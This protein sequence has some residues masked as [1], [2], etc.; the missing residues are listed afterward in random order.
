[1]RIKQ[2]N[3]VKDR[4][5]C[6]RKEEASGGLILRADYK[7]KAVRIALS[8]CAALLIIR[9]PSQRQWRQVEEGRRKSESI[10][11]ETKI[12]NSWVK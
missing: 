11:K 5:L 12:G 9:E 6:N 10:N 3:W 1:M 4:F 7:N 8:C 2:L